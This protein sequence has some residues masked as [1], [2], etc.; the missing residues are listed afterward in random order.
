MQVEAGDVG[1]QEVGEEEAEGED[2]M[3]SP[4]HGKTSILRRDSKSLTKTR[5]KL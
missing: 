2:L 3:K 1:L 5:Q 4:F